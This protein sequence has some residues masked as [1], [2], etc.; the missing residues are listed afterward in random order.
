MSVR[1]WSALVAAVLLLVLHL[2]A[3]RLSRPD[4][5]GGW[6]E[7]GERARAVEALLAARAADE[8]DSRALEDYFGPDDGDLEIV[9]TSPPAAW[10]PF[11]R[12]FGEA[13]VVWEPSPETGSYRLRV[14]GRFSD[15]AKLLGDIDRDPGPLAVR[16]L[17]MA[18][19][20]A[21]VS[22]LLELESPPEVE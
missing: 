6:E 14:R 7:V 16:R 4:E 17:E 3:E 11:L 15:L 12:P 20:E 5:G 19:G 1:S 10:R 13:N 2:L 8:E 9:T 21:G 18:R 22:L